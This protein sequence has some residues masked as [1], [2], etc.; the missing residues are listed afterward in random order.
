MMSTNSWGKNIVAK[1]VVRLYIQLASFLCAFLHRV[2]IKFL[3]VNN[4]LVTCKLD[5]SIQHGICRRPDFAI[6]SRKNV[7]IWHQTF[8]QLRASRVVKNMK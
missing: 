6:D 1:A 8:S 5:K 2:I 3:R 7:Q 4:V